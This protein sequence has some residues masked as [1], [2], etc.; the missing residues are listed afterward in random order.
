MK[1]R[2][3]RG[4]LEVMQAKSQT[5][6]RGPRRGGGKLKEGQQPVA[7][8][9]DPP[10]NRKKKVT[11]RLADGGKKIYKRLEKKET[12]RKTIRPGAELAVL[13]PYE[14]TSWVK[15]SGKS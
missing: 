12:R 3:D 6:A 14:R 4:G 13:R 7:A 11:V 2:D 10:G 15:T 1:E 8:A 5:Q 9:G